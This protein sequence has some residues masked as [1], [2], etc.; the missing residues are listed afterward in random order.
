M[1]QL[2]HLNYSFEEVEILKTLAKYHDE[3]KIAENIL[4]S[5]LNEYE[6]TQ[7]KKIIQKFYLDGIWDFEDT[8]NGKGQSTFNFDL[9]NNI[10]EYPNP[11]P[12]EYKEDIN[13]NSV[14][15]KLYASNLETSEAKYITALIKKDLIDQP[16]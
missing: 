4:F 13:L 8:A 16:K 5:G 2:A 3:P 7:V 11:I 15:E 1:N 12:K 9:K 6:Y 10:L 14:L